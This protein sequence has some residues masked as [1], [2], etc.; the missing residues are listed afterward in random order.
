MDGWM[1]DCYIDP[2]G[3]DPPLYIQYLANS[4]KSF[5]CRC[6]L[7][8][9]VSKSVIPFICLDKIKHHISVGKEV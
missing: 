2:P 8:A 9:V 6:F 5:L 3:I 4:V 1:T 7:D